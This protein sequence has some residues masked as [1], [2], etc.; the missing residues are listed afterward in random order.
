VAFIDG[1]DAVIFDTKTGRR[2]RITKTTGS[3]SSPR[4]RATIRMSPSFATESLHRS[5]EAE[6]HAVVAQLTDVAP[7]RPEPRPTESQKFVSEEEARLIEFVREQKAQK[8]RTRR[9]RSRTSCLPRAQN[10]RPP[11]I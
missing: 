3:E 4:W 2:M 10:A 8:R 7:K 11:R 5:V 6:S 1:G 9:R